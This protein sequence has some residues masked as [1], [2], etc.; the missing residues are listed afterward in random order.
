MILADYPRLLRDSLAPLGRPAGC[1]L[2][3]YP[4]HVNIGDHLIWA[5]TLRLLA[6]ELGT[7]VRYSS[8]PEGFS[9]QRM[10]TALGPDDPIL[11]MGGGN[12]G[13]LWPPIQRFMERIIARHPRRRIVILPQTL[14]FQDPDNAR[15]AAAVFNRHPDLTLFLRDHR[16]H[17]EA[18]RLFPCCRVHL[19]P[20]M[21]LGLAEEAEVFATGHPGAGPTTLLLRRRDRESLTLPAGEASALEVSADWVSYERGWRMGDRRVPFSR[22]LIGWYREWWQRRLAF[23][24]EYRARN[25]WFAALRGH[26]VFGS[27]LES[28]HGRFSLGLIWDGCRQLLAHRAVVSN[29]LHGHLLSCLLGIPSVLLDN[30]YGKNRLFHEAW[31][32]DVRGSRFVGAGGD[33]RA[34]LEEV[35]AAGV[36][37]AGQAEPDV[38]DRHSRARR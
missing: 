8:S 36:R 33:V 17:E 24:E 15:R 13:D 37:R 22:T 31:L 35:L 2:L 26:R 6:G 27:M 4:E 29:R 3:N 23:P 16:S 30:S 25:A 10:E 1:A 12:L 11:L 20:D 19:A 5:G 18:R 9:A 34:A 28:R 21:A 32:R 7:E 14:H 38:R